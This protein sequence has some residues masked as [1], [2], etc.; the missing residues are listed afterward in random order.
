MKIFILLLMTVSTISFGKSFIGKEFPP[1]PEGY[2]SRNGACIG[3][4]LGRDRACD[5]SILELRKGKPVLILSGQKLRMNGNKAQWLITDQIN[6]PKINRGNLL[7]MGVC[8]RNGLI[9]HSISA[10]VIDSD[11]EWLKASKWAIKINLKTGKIH[12]IPTRDIEC[13]NEGWGI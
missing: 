13:E 1:Y 3:Y 6:Y 11:K 9:D 10:V 4:S 2:E 7:V 8:R 5:F 12:S